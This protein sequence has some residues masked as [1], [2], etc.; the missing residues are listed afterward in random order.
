MVSISNNRNNDIPPTIDNDDN[1]DDEVNMLLNDDAAQPPQQVQSDNNNNGN[2]NNNNNSDNNNNNDKIDS[3][4]YNVP[5]IN[6]DKNM[7]T[8]QEVDE[9]D[10][11]LFCRISSS[12]FNTLSSSS[13]LSS[14]Q[15]STILTSSSFLSSSDPFNPSPPPSYTNLTSSY[16]RRN[17]IRNEFLHAYHA[18]THYAK[19]ED[20][21]KP[22]SKR[23]DGNI[24]PPARVD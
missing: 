16:D 23:G 11:R 5:N 21:L 15:C 20:E 19:N 10:C 8:H 13:L 24:A 14:C 3:N 4:N 22:V 7:N 12:P 18:Y 9:Y 6:D 2:N 17:A 1:I